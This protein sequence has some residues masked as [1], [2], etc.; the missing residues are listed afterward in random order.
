MGIDALSSSVLIR[1]I[2]LI[3]AGISLVKAKQAI[4]SILSLYLRPNIFLPF[5]VRK[6]LS[7]SGRT[8]SSAGLILSS[9]TS[10]VFL[11]QLKK[12]NSYLNL[13][14]CIFK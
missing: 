7:S 13:P 3:V 2:S 11:I 12:S 9:Y 14:I 8:G 1:S 5:D 10:S 4:P 6:S